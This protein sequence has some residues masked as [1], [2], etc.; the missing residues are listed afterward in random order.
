VAIAPAVAT[1]AP[2]TQNGNS[3]GDEQYCAFADE[4]GNAAIPATTEAKKM[5]RRMSMEISR[6][7]ALTPVSR[8][9]VNA[10][11]RRLI[12]RLCID[13]S[14]VAPEQGNAAPTTP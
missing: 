5:I 12:R 9:H 4:S 6:I 10:I 7:G 3:S 13:L 8:H 11:H 14:A 1:A 2:A